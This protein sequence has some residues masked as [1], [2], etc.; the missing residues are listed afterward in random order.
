[1]PFRLSLAALLG[2]ASLLPLQAYA[3]ATADEAET[4]DAAQDAAVDRI[5]VIGRASP[6]STLDRALQFQ[7]RQ[8]RDIFDSEPGIDIAGGTRNGQRLFLRGVEGSN[9][10]ISVDGARQGR[11]LYNH[12]GGLL[13]VDPEILKRVDIQAGPAAADQ[14]FGALGGSIRFETIDAQDQLAP[15]QSLGGFTRASYASASQARRLAAGASVR[16]SDE[17]AVLAY[18]TGTRFNDLRLG[19]GERAPFSGGDDRTYLIKLSALNMGDHTLRTSYER[20]DASGLNFMQRGDYPWQLQ[21]EDFRTRPPQNQSLVRDTYT[22]RY[23]YN[24][25]SPLIDAGLSAYSNRN[26]F[27]APESNGERFISEV[28][29]GDIRNTA[30]F[31]FGAARLETTFG[32]DYFDDGG[33]ASRTDQGT[34]YMTNRNRGL[35]VQNRL[36]AG[37]WTFYAGVRHD[38]FSADYGPRS[39]SGDAVSFNA[40]GEAAFHPALTVFAGYGESARGFGNLPIHF[41]RNAVEGL[42]FN[43]TANG[44]LDPERGR[45]WEAGVR[46]RG[47]EAGPGVLGYQ[48]VVF[49]TEISDAVLFDQPGSGGLGGRPVT[50]LRNHG[51][52]IRIE[53]WEAGLDYTLDRVFTSVR[54]SSSDLENLPSEPQ[55]IARLGA[56]RGDQLVWDTRVSLLGE[57]SAGYTLRHTWALRDVPAGQ[58]VYIPKSGYTLHDVQIT[59]EPARWRGIAVEVSATNLTDELYIAHSTLTQNGLATAEAGRDLRLSLSYRF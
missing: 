50:N 12:R 4:D 34:R 35:F 48:A 58:I 13:N 42:T 29:G 6:V 2:A 44:A 27:Y 55:F 59:W 7:A 56:P 1:M 17:I 43:G 20:N 57:W 10:N 5:I 36:Y 23:G 46:G 8:V 9:L 21:P 53:G 15:G 14:G 18:A 49:R 39:A 37:L 25:S 26:D 30:R 45:Q 41:A 3:Q 19:G 11:N 40:G 16:L 51:Q 31:A 47:L 54:Y 24:P 22:L 52:T 32:A 28:T 38:D 33:T